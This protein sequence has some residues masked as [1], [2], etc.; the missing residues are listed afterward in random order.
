MGIGA[1]VL[2]AAIGAVLAFAVKAS[3]SGVDIKTIGVILL[4]AGIIIAVVDG[5]YFLPRRRRTTYVD[6]AV[7][8]RTTTV[9]DDRY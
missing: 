8:P 5:A 7:A 1:G 6:G 3:I 4:I 2:I 9:V